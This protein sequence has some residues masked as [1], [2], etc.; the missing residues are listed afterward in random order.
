M[1]RQLLL[2]PRGF[3]DA[4]DE[5]VELVHGLREEHRELRRRQRSDS[6]DGYP[7]SS[8][9]GG[10]RPS[11]DEDGE[12]LP[13]H[14]DPAGELVA[15][16]DARPQADPVFAALE[17]V[18][19]HVHEARRRLEQAGSAAAKAHP[20]AQLA[21]QAED[22]AWCWPCARQ[23]VMSPTYRDSGDG[24][25]RP[26]PRCRPCYEWWLA[27]GPQGRRT[28]QPPQLILARA[29]G[30]RITAQMV[31]DLAPQHQAAAGG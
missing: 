28:E 1:T 3:E 21:E 22:R 27:S 23:G 14:G 9:G 30:E 19:R 24:E 20:P 16:R 17:S 6:P 29:R 8:L 5:I 26:T 7:P 25:S 4:C 31:R 12:L 18:V 11:T 15:R 10:S 2:T 13:P